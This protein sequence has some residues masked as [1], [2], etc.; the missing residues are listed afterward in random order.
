MR[1]SFFLA[2]AISAGLAIG[3]ASTPGS[4]RVT[5]SS[6]P[7][8]AQDAAPQDDNAQYDAEQAR[9]RAEDAEQ[10]ERYQQEQ[11]QQRMQDERDQNDYQREEE[12]QR[13]QEETDRLN[14][15][16]QEPQ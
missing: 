6:T 11:E 8:L 7:A 13:R 2:G 5:F 14:S 12:E 4:N 10:Q 16:R 3:L 15:E 1:S 9:Q